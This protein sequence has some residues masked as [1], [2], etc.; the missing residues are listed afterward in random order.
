MLPLNNHQELESSRK[1]KWVKLSLFKK[2]HYR[3][4]NIDQITVNIMILNVITK[5]HSPLI[6]IS[7]VMLSEIIFCF[8]YSKI[9]TGIDS[10]AKRSRIYNITIFY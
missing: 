5:G 10:Q 7:A 8:L 6:C 2:R 9:A 3:H 1:L 4:K